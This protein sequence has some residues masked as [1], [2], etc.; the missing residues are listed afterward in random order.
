MSDLQSVEQ[1]EIRIRALE[2][3]TSWLE[4]YSQGLLSRVNE[5]GAKLSQLV[6]MLE[7]FADALRKV[8][9]P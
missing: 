3:R 8:A 4:G 9:K 2:A 6:M 1:L 7:D 5:Q